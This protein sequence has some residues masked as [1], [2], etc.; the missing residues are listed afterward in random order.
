MMSTLQV[1]NSWS[2]NWLILRHRSTKLHPQP[3]SHL[4]NNFQA[5]LCAR[6]EKRVLSAVQ[7][8]MYILTSFLE[9]LMTTHIKT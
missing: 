8:E 7:E 9:D 2:T 4:K 3:H 1:R 6:V 5:P